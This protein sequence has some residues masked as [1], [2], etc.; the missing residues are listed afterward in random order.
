NNQG[1]AGPNDRLCT[2]SADI[3][4]QI[5]TQH[6]GWNSGAKMEAG[7]YHSCRK[8]GRKPLVQRKQ[9]DRHPHEIGVPA[10]RR[11][12][13]LLDCEGDA[14]QKREFKNKAQQSRHARV[15]FAFIGP[16]CVGEVA[17]R[18][19]LRPNASRG[20]NCV[21]L[22][23]PNPS[24][25]ASAVGMFMMQLGSGLGASL[26]SLRWVGVS[27]SWISQISRRAAA[28]FQFFIL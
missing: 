28:S 14:K 23:L 21:M 16:S 13:S 24:G 8:P 4:V 2:D 11:A 25:P 9:H 26:G 17:H 5:F 6:R 15:P 1:K 20:S 10:E 27:R 12:Q 3:G 22:E 7:G 19:F 18:L